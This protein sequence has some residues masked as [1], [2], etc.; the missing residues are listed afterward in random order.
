MRARI[1]LGHPPQGDQAL[2]L[3]VLGHVDDHHE[4]AERRHADLDEQR[5]VVDDHAVIGDRRLPRD[6]E[7]PDGG[8]GDG[9]EVGAGGVVAEHQCP[10]GRPVEGAVGCDDAGAEAL[11]DGGQCGRAGLDRFTGQQVVVD[12]DRAVAREARADGALAR[13]DAT[14]QT[15]SEHGSPPVSGAARTW[16]RGR[17][18]CGWPWGCLGRSCRASCSTWRVARSAAAR[19]GSG[20]RAR[21]RF[22]C[23]KAAIWSPVAGS[24]MMSTARPVPWSPP[25]LRGRRS[26]GRPG[27]WRTPR[28]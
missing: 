4:V 23:R 19:S 28:E 22:C 27:T 11:G 14:G 8:V 16:R 15:E 7:I 6:G 26:C 17:G 10:E 25:P 24:T 3:N 5:V 21:T 18:P 2:E 13:A 12:D 9:F 1:R 20:C